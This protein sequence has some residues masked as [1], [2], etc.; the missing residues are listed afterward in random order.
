MGGGG[1]IR[2]AKAF[3]TLPTFI[4]IGD[5]DFTLGGAKSLHQTLQKTGATNVRYK[6]YP[7]IEHLVIVREALPD[8]FA[9]FDEI[10]SKK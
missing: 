1:R 5:K 3:A 2:D 8:A 9:M 6:E 7:D 10:V 4:G